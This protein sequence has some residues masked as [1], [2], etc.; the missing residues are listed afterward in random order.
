M[1]IRKIG[2][3][4]I[5]LITTCLLTILYF[6]LSAHTIDLQAALHKISKT[7]SLYS[8]WF[9]Q[10]YWSS[11]RSDWDSAT[12]AKHIQG[13]ADSLRDGDDFLGY[14]DMAKLDP[15]ETLTGALDAL[16]EKHRGQVLILKKQPMVNMLKDLGELGHEYAFTAWSNEKD[17][18]DHLAESFKEITMTM[19]ARR[20]PQVAALKDL[21]DRLTWYSLWLEDPELYLLSLKKELNWAGEYSATVMKEVLNTAQEFSKLLIS[22]LCDQSSVRQ[23]IRTYKMAIPLVGNS[24]QSPKDLKGNGFYQDV[25]GNGKLDAA[26]VVALKQGLASPVVQDHV[27]A[28]DYNEDGVV[29]SKDVDWLAEKI[30]QSS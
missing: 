3:M 27:R 30:S 23:W 28:F 6:C 8:Q 22:F 14:L 1:T 7:S 24:K 11:R 25:N 2:I 18:G 12:L 20:V 26:D 17:T 9:E 21:V 16:A 29:D 4:A 10:G 19:S 13:I 5:V 15:D